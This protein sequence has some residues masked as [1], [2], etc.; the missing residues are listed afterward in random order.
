VTT[1]TKSKALAMMAQPQ[2]AGSDFTIWVTHGGECRWKAA[3]Q[4]GKCGSHKL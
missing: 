3:W 2:D 1:A 4:K